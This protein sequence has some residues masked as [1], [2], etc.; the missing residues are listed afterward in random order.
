MPS[1]V[2]CHLDCQLDWDNEGVDQDLY[3]IAHLIVHWE[4]ELSV[5]LGLT[6][7][8]IHD[9]KAIHL[10][11]PELQ[12]YAHSMHTGPMIVVIG[13]VVSGS[14]LRAVRDL[15]GLSES[16]SDG[17]LSQ[18]VPVRTLTMGHTA[19][20]AC[21]NQLTGTQAACPTATAK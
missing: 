16:I 3:E 4:E 20:L 15:V 19:R 9:I 2:R 21:L 18:S 13:L 5:L 14:I 17:D 8:D 10:N 7:V 12:R 11:R 6:A 1:N